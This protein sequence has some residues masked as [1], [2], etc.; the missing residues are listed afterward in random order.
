MTR[1]S[2][3]VN[4]LLREEISDIVQ[5]NL[6]DPRL[7]GLISI[8]SVETSPD[9]RHARVFVSVMGSE[10]QQNSTFAALYAAQGFLRHELRT[11]LKA[12]RVVPDI[13]F[14]PDTSIERGARLSHLLDQALHGEQ[15]ATADPADLSD[16]GDRG[17]RV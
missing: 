12:L 1:R 5:R 16:H 11:R 9:F 8:T 3:R 2:E 17:D 7:G 15:D 14:R 6:K 13:A 10:E 4:E